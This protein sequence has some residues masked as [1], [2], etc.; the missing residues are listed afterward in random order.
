MSLLLL[1]VS[2]NDAAG[3]DPDAFDFLLR[4]T[5]VDTT[6]RNAVNVLVKGLKADGT[7]PLFYFFYP[8]IGPNQGAYMTNLINNSYFINQGSGMRYT[9]NGFGGSGGGGQYGDTGF[10][11]SVS[12]AQDS[13]T[14][15]INIVEDFTENSYDFGVDN[16]GQQRG[17]VLL[18]SIPGNELYAGV[19]QAPNLHYTNT[20]PWS[21]E[22]TIARNISTEFKI[23][24]DGALFQTSVQNST[25][26]P[27][28][29]MYICAGN[30][31][32]SPVLLSTRT[33]R[34][35]W[36][37]SGMNATQVLNTYN[38]LQTFFTATGK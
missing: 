19:S 4:A 16:G 34:S 31:G 18:S 32:G 33:Y 27:N 5:I 15:S 20:A 38:R 30:N 25:A 10:N 13:K 1:G 23:Y 14:Y 26:N 17:D 28:F 36:A 22:Y 24:K 6:Q 7:W 11:P 12:M 35:F 29:N 9:S 37:A 8:F 2:G 3:F 21:G